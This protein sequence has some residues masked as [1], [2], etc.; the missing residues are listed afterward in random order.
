MENYDDKIEHK[1]KAK[2]GICRRFRRYLI[3]GLKEYNI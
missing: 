2:D 3:I 1:R